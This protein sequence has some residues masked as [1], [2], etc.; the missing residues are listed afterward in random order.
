MRS[1]IFD[2]ET[3]GLPYAKKVS[4]ENLA[5]WPHI[6]QLSYVIYDSVLNE[7]VYSFDAIIRLEEGITIPEQSIRI[8][9]ITEEIMRE[10]GVQLEAVLREFVQHLREVDTIVGHNVTFD[11]NMIHAEMLRLERTR[12]IEENLEYFNQ[13]KNIYCTMKETIELCDLKKVNR[14]GRS[15]RKWPKLVELHEKLFARMPNN[16]HNSYNDILVTLRCYVKIRYDVDLLDTCR[17]FQ[18]MTDSIGL[19]S[20]LEESIQ[21]AECI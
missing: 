20:T 7:I 2:T 5:A 17:N 15:E 21:T 3:T 9:G 12:E 4:P 10:K 6:V 13:Y 16:L 8:H 11:I 1:L 19:Y 18:E 14:F